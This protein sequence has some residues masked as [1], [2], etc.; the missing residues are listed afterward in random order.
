MTTTFTDARLCIDGTL[1]TPSKLTVSSESGLITDISSPVDVGQ[2][3]SSSSLQTIDLKGAILA[4]GF[5]E[6]QT[7]GLRGFHFTHFDNKGSYAKKLDEVAKYLP[8]TGV[9][10]FWATLPTISSDGFKEVRHFSLSDSPDLAA[11]FRGFSTSCLNLP[12]VYS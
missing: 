6:L 7:N 11:L 9:T 8:R 10:G 3:Q 12:A 4:P 5:L 1:T 2:I